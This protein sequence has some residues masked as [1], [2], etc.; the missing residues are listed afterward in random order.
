MAPG[1]YAWWYLD[2]LSDDGEMGVTLI[3]F[4]GSVFSPYY[5]LARRLGRADPEHHCALNVAIYD[6]SKKRW[7]MTE[8]GRGQVARTDSTFT[9]GPSALAWD[10]TALI[11]HVDE[12]TVPFPRRM[13][14]T[15]RV[16]PAFCTGNR[17][18]LDAHARHTWMPLAPRA[19]VEVALHEPAWRWSGEGYMDANAG[20]APLEEAFARWTWSRARAGDRTAILYDVTARDGTSRALAF[21]VNGADVITPAEPPPPLA[22]PRTLW[23]LPRAT[24]A[25][26]GVRDPPRIVRTLED[27]PFYARSS[28]AT[29]WRGEPAIAMHESLSLDRFRAPWVQMLLPFRMPRRGR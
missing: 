15:I 26:E 17:V 24:R 19:R 4:V 10:G 12:V 8:R 20:S 7:T 28:V 16:L 2:A 11:I 23:G 29:R 3:A 18:V 9:V 27:A 14:G 22:L 25:H 13:R 1:G 6:R 21:E 5:A